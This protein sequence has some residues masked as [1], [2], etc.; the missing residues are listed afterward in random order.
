MKLNELLEVM[1][2]DQSVEVRVDGSCEFDMHAGDIIR[3]INQ[4]ITAREID[5][6]TSPYKECIKVYLK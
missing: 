3:C 2:Y 1:R 4:Q 6:I 5:Y